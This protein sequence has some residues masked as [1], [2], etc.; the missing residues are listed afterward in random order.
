M[1]P[2][3]LRA[4]QSSI[5]SEIERM[6]EAPRQRISHHRRARSDTFFS[7]E[8]IDDL[9]LFDPSDVDFSSLDFLNAPTPQTQPQPQPSPM[10]VDS[11]PEET[12]SNGAP[13]IPLP[14]GRH[15]RSFSVDSE[16]NFF[17]DL[18]AT[19]DTQFARPTSSGGRKGHHHRSNSMDG[20]TSSGSFNM[21]SILAA[22]N[23]KDGAKKNMG[24][25]S[26][27]LAELALLDPKRA[28]RILANRQS[29]AR[30]K[31]RK[32]KYTGELERKVQT[33]QNEAT[34][35]SAQVTMLQRGTSD[36]TTENK[37]LKM[38]LQALEQQAELRDALNEALRG[39]LNR[40][41]IAAGE[42]PQGNG[43]SFNNNRSQFSSQLGNNK[44]QQMSTN[45]QPSSFMDFNKRG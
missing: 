33:L 36:L 26:D 7:G 39:E 31:E 9:L 40:L 16:S 41:K 25:A 1:E 15:V 4:N 29:A 22:V 10:S 5:L 19:E 44:N 24:M 28:K 13:P 37:H 35:L 42:I 32:I 34:T 3:S 21:D 17:D 11:P 23:C 20:A 30:S 2:S 45:G 6:P 14:P 27:R 8:S 38:R 12:S 43:N 18:T